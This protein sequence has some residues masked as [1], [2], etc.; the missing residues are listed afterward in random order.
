M[1]KCSV[2]IN[3]VYSIVLPIRPSRIRFSRIRPS[4]R[5]S[6]IVLP[7]LSPQGG[8]AVRRRTRRRPDVRTDVCLDTSANRRL[9][10]CAVFHCDTD[11]W[12]SI[13]RFCCFR[14]RKKVQFELPVCVR[15]LASPRAMPSASPPA[16]VDV[17]GRGPCERASSTG[18]ASPATRRCAGAELR[19]RPTCSASDGFADVGD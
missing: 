1:D 11:F 19:A 14:F 5:T 3:G 15:M 8:P 7:I 6:S 9:G 13:R 2:H 17:A 4:N 18:A 12:K 10:C 16:L